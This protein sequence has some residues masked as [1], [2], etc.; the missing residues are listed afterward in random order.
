[1]IFPRTH[2]QHMPSPLESGSE[3]EARHVRPT[4]GRENT[5]EASPFDGFPATFLA[6]AIGIVGIGGSTLVRDIVRDVRLAATN[7]ALLV[8]SEEPDLL[9]ELSPTGRPDTQIQD[10]S[11][12]DPV[13]AGVRHVDLEEGK[14]DHGPSFSCNILSPFKGESPHR[15]CQRALALLQSETHDWYEGASE[16]LANL[17]A[18][19]IRATTHDWNRVDARID[20]KP[21]ATLRDLRDLL[22]NL[23]VRERVLNDAD[24]DAAERWYW[25]LVGE[26]DLAE[27][28]RTVAPVVNLCRRFHD[29]TWDILC[30][31]SAPDAVD[32]FARRL[33]VG[34]GEDDTMLLLPSRGHTGD[35]RIFAGLLACALAWVVSHGHGQRPH[36]TDETRRTSLVIVWDAPTGDGHRGFEDLMDISQGMIRKD[37]PEITVIVRARSSAEM[38]PGLRTLVSFEKDGGRAARAYIMDGMEKGPCEAMWWVDEAMRNLTTGDA[39]IFRKSGGDGLY[40]DAGLLRLRRQGR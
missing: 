3:A 27:W 6:D 22:L 30:D 23:D 29:K 33:L 35:R 10:H 39:R 34:E 31:R 40:E 7:R 11:T 38:P 25:R 9:R 5:G 26:Y 8:V 17:C 32:T 28:R 4:D 18:L 36:S 24:A 15:A 2:T 12:V 20:G 1:M 37:A 14:D 19:A 16:L 21:E 13:F